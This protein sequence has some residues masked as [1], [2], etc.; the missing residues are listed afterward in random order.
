[1]ITNRSYRQREHTALNKHPSSRKLLLAMLVAVVA[2][3]LTS[4]DNSEGLVAVQQPTSVSVSTPTSRSSTSSISTQPSATI[5]SVSEEG[6]DAMHLTPS[7]YQVAVTSNIG[8]GKEVVGGEKVIYYVTVTNQGSYPDAYLITFHSDLGWADPSGLP[9]RIELQPH[10]RATYTVTASVP[11][12]ASTFT[13]DLVKITAQS[14]S[15]PATSAASSE[16]RLTIKCLL[17]FADLTPTSDKAEKVYYLLC[18]EL[19]D[20]TKAGDGSLLAEPDKAV[21]FSELKAVLDKMRVRGIG[22]SYTKGNDSSAYVRRADAAVAFV[23]AFSLAEPEVI[24]VSSFND[25]PANYFAL[26]EIEAV[27]LQGPMDGEECTTP[28][29]GRC[30]KPEEI[31]TRA[32]LSSILYPLVNQ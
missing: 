16:V 25:V 32:E 26:A 14:L 22:G 5:A 6:L 21:T 13:G 19:L 24:S 12:T 17:N 30:F 11:Y 28:Q 4:C 15:V 20:Y 8:D 18:R 3:Q 27:Y 31:L 2:V 9:T 29:Q 10:S 7:I 1:M 23:Q